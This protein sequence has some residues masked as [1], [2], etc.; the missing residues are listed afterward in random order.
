MEQ[1]NYW[2]SKA[3][4]IYADS[5]IEL[6]KKMNEFAKDK[7]VIAWQIFTDASFTKL[8]CIVTYKEKETNSK[9]SGPTK[10]DIVGVRHPAELGQ[11]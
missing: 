3:F 5:F 7:F 4:Y 6:C 2:R 10:A 9:V 1:S 11:I 8:H